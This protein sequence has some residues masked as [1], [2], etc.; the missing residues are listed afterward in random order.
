MTDKSVSNLSCSNISVNNENLLFLSDKSNSLQI[1]PRFLL[2]FASTLHNIIPQP[3]QFKISITDTDNTSELSFFNGLRYDITINWGDN[4]DLENVIHAADSS[5]ISY[6]YT[7]KISHTYSSASDYTISITPKSIYLF[8]G[9]ILEKSK[10]TEV[11]SWG[12][13]KWKTM[14]G[15]FYSTN[16]IRLP[17]SA[18][19]L[20]NVKNMEYMFRDAE[21]FN[22]DISSWNTSNVTNMENMFF[23]AAA[24]NQDISN[25]DVSSVE[26]MGQ[27]FSG[28]I[29]FNN[30]GNS[31]DWN[32]SK[33]TNMY[34]MFQLTTFNQDISNW[35]VSSVE[36][37]Q[38][39]FFR[40]AF[41]Q[42]ISKWDVSSVQNLENMF[43]YATAFN[44]DI[45]KWDVSSV[46]NMSSMFE[47][48]PL[49]DKVPIW[50][51][52]EI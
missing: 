30:G 8:P 27:M 15:M 36:N 22:Q 47:G 50:W 29:A 7:K 34:G 45:N 2:K 19:D 41:N 33:V 39:M 1:N 9:I 35:D 46:E 12:N 37:M 51:K 43:R 38:Q 17:P 52:N 6:D 23:N 18:P 13:T 16:L 10:I 26:N 32:T 11:I 31:L 42:D 25:W 20:S 4:G 40:A 21:V 24:F 44:Q 48:S 5:E 28:A 3:F 14:H 49:G